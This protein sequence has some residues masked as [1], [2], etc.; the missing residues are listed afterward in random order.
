MIGATYGRYRIVEQLGEGGMGTVW[1]A[2]DTLLGRVV[3]LKLLAPHLAESADARQRF[4]REAR[5]ASKLE[6]PNIAA[7]FDVGEID[8]QV[9]IA[10]QF[11]DAQTLA[12]RL[13][14]GPLPLPALHQLAHGA[15]AALAHAHARG[16]VHRDI[17]TGNIMLRADGEP[18]IVDFGLARA[19]GDTTLTRT[20]TTLG[21]AR[22]LAPEQWRGEPGDARTDLWS[23]GVVLYQA[24]TGRLPFAGDTPEAVMYRVL[25]EEPERPRRL[26]DELP[27]TLE[28]VLQRLLEKVASDRLVSARDLMADLATRPD[29][30]A[31]ETS[32]GREQATVAL[33]RWWRRQERRRF[34]PVQ[35]AILLAV[36]VAFT[37]GA[38]II[39]QYLGTRIPR[40]LAVL[41][42]RNTSSD[43]EGTAQIG[44]ALGEELAR[45][46]GSSRAFRVL[47]W[48]TTVRFD[49]TKQSPAELAKLLHADVLLTGSYRSESDQ[50]EVN[51]ELIDGRNGVQSWSQRYVRVESDLITLQSELAEGVSRRMSPSFGPRERASLAASAPAN[52]DAYRYFILASSYWHSDDPTTMP[53]VE[54]FFQK[55]VELDSMLA[56]AWVGLGAVRTDR[57]FRGAAGSTQDLI[58]ADSM[59]H[60]A[61]RIQPGLAVAERGIIRGAYELAESGSRRL[62]LSMAARALERDPMDVEQLTT[63]EWGMAQGGLAELALPILDRALR[64]DPQSQTLAWHSVIVLGWSGHP[65]R[66]LAAGADYIRR[67][68]EDLEIYTFMAGAAARLG[69]YDQAVLL[70]KRAVELSKESPAHY[71][72]TLLAKLYLA[73]G[74]THSYQQLASRVVPELEVLYRAQPDNLRLGAKLAQFYAWNGDEAAFRQ[75]DRLD[76][77]GGTDVSGAQGGVGRLAQL[78]YLDEALA[79][80]RTMETDDDRYWAEVVDSIGLPA[81]KLAEAPSMRRLEESD[82]YIAWQS[83][84]DASQQREFDKYREVVAK[85]FASDPDLPAPR[86]RWPRISWP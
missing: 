13:A 23:L 69:R 77:G 59:F 39:R 35:V 30:V 52:P 85:Y 25:N 34:G 47:P 84:V 82:E 67:F 75:L 22:Y 16:V 79:V 38:I 78:G 48:E 51:A 33:R 65:Y 6:H 45:R 54:P 20:G 2:E 24:A 29:D 62:A 50:V 36:S 49:E 64:L 43:R 81:H 11:I 63:A 55:A 7:V 68:G 8:R 19:T 61:L 10:Y 18:V 57:Y 26:R 72:A 44:E 56:M 46:L 58:S 37:A 31:G 53:L 70:Y 71:S 40:V 15:A 5:A 9:F 41:P 21:T 1:R 27:E 66:T 76:W 4:I 80:L 17:T 32:A 60:R 12:K 83:A 86:N 73:L 74:D 42:M 28:R 3:A 14:N